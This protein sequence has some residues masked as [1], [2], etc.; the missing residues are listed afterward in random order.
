MGNLAEEE[1]VLVYVID[2]TNTTIPT[3]LLDDI[4]RI[5]EEKHLCAT[6]E[7]RDAAMKRPTNFQDGE[8]W[9]MVKLGYTNPPRQLVKH[10]LH[11]L[12]AVSLKA[13]HTHICGASADGNLTMKTRV[14][15]I[16][17]KLEDN[18]TF[19]HQQ[20]EWDRQA[21]ASKNQLQDDKVSK[22]TL[23]CT[24]L[25]SS[26]AMLTMV[27]S[28]KTLT[29]SVAVTLLDN[30]RRTKAGQGTWKCSMPAEFIHVEQMSFQ[31]LMSLKRMP[32]TTLDG[33]HHNR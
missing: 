6:K 1:W 32:H 14:E 10:H 33:I 12:D 16:L 22:I 24:T 3:S 17:K 2:E 23:A 30:R 15:L 8:V 18:E 27:T 13:E 31:E 5:L 21:R 29:T 25:G 20:A 7:D 26:A 28:V 19:K 9:L 4:K 11:L